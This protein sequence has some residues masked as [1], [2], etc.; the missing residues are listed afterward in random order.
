MAPICLK[1]DIFWPI[2]F[3]KNSFRC[4]LVLVHGSLA[5]KWSFL[6]IRFVLIYIFLLHICRFFPKWQEVSLFLSVWITISSILRVFITIW[7][8]RRKF[9]RIFKSILSNFDKRSWTIAYGWDEFWWFLSGVYFTY[10]YGV[11]DYFNSLHYL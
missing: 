8:F 2:L 5:L 11:C 10:I 9:E 1:N 7:H 3:I 4:R 6:N